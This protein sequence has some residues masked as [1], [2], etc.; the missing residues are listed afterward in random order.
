MKIN[1]KQIKTISINMN[2]SV[3]NADTHNILLTKDENSE[4][5]FSIK[6]IKVSEDIDCSDLTLSNNVL[7][8]FKLNR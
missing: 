5:G 1:H 6:F 3:W 2:N 7:N 8:K 4:L